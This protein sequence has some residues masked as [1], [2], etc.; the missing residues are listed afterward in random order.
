MC[1]ACGLYQK[2]HSVRICPTVPGKSVESQ[3][4]LL[5][6]VVQSHCWLGSPGATGYFNPVTVNVPVIY[7]KRASDVR[8]RY[9]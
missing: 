2:L 4:D 6:G 7:D 3:A 8:G 9:T 5:R 1:N